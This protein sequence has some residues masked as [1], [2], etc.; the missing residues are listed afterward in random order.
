M[1]FAKEK[2]DDIFHFD[3]PRPTMG[4]TISLG[5]GQEVELSYDTT[6]VLHNEKRFGA[7]GIHPSL[8]SLT[9]ELKDLKLESVRIH[10]YRLHSGEYLKFRL[11]MYRKLDDYISHC[12]RHSL[13]S[14]MKDKLGRLD[15]QSDEYAKVQ[16]DWDK[17]LSEHEAANEGY[18]SVFT[19]EER[20]LF[21]TF[22]TKHIKRLSKAKMRSL[23][24]KEFWIDYPFA[25]QNAWDRYQ[26]AKKK[27]FVRSYKLEEKLHSMNE[28]IDL[29]E[30]N[31]KDVLLGLEDYVIAVVGKEKLDLVDKDAPIG[32]N[33]ISILMGVQGFRREKAHEVAITIMKDLGIPDAEDVCQYKFY[34][35]INEDFQARINLSYMLAYNPSMVIVD[36]ASITWNRKLIEEIISILI[37]I[38]TKRK[39]I[40][41]IYDDFLND[42]TFEPKEVF[43]ASIDGKVTKKE[44]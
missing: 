21:K 9:K 20:S 27:K 39:F 31:K 30:N 36:C 16:A 8:K 23:R 29:R 7:K 18:L 3:E 25:F 32:E 38:R 35:F 22:Q 14:S 42:K 37:K 41:A 40:L 33:M 26:M 34:Q 28:Q 4:M 11:D 6:Y 10:D 15:P 12:E 13:L 2:R 44:G 5:D 17:K 19:D 1:K 24:Y 43:V